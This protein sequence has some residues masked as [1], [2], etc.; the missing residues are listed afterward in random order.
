MSKG[1]EVVKIRWKRCTLKRLR[2]WLLFLLVVL[3]WASNW[4]VMKMGLKYVSP[5]N[6]VLHRFLL[7]SLALSPLLIFLRRKIPQDKET[8]A[9]LLLLGVINAVCVASTN[10]GLVYEKSGV[11]AILTYTQ[12]LFVFCFAVLFLKEKAG[13]SRLLGVFIGFSGV[14]ALS[15][16]KSNPVEGLS[17]SSFFLLVGAFLW[18]VTIVY[19]KRLLSYVDPVITNVFQ[20]TASAL[21]LAPL[22]SS[23]EGFSFPLT[24]T[25]VLIALYTSIF[26]SGIALTLWVYLLRE[27]DATVLSSSSFMVPIVALFFGWLLI[28]ENVEVESLL[29]IGL[30]MSGVYLVNKS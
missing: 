5:L 15:I 14:V 21:L 17:Y 16:G 29:G 30:V 19:Y 3:I 25:Y 6:F 7:S 20:L 9:K 10:I 28:S 24:E 4:A 18:A 1:I 13:I 12:P 11:S 2:N 8:L 27:E 23:L 26:A 22:A